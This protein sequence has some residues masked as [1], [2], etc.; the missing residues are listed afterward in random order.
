MKLTPLAEV[1]LYHPHLYYGYGEERG[2]SYQA[3]GASQESSS[4]G[5]INLVNDR[6][7]GVVTL[8]P[9]FLPQQNGTALWTL[10]GTSS[11]TA[12][13]WQ[14]GVHHETKGVVV[15]QP[16]GASGVTWSAVTA[17]TTVEPRW[18]L[19]YWLSNPGTFV[20]TTA[21]NAPGM[22]VTY[23]S[24][25]TTRYQFRVGGA[26]HP[27]M[28]VST[29]SGSAFHLVD[30]LRSSHTNARGFAAWA[31]LMLQQ[32]GD[33]VVCGIGEDKMRHYNPSFGTVVTGG[34]TVEGTACGAGLAW[35]P[36]HFQASGTGFGTTV[37]RGYIT[38]QT[39]TVKMAG[40]VGTGNTMSGT[41]TEFGDTAFEYEF[42]LTAGTAANGYGTSTPVMRSI[43]VTYPAV[44]RAPTVSPMES[45]PRLKSL[46]ENIRFDPTSL[47]IYTEVTANFDNHEKRFSLNSGIRACEV[48][49]GYAELGMTR[50]LSGLAG[51]LSEWTTAPGSERYVLHMYDRSV[52]LKSP[53]G[54]IVANLP[55]MDGWCIYKAMRYLANYGGIGD[56]SLGFPICNGDI[57][58]PCGHY[59]LP[60]GD[61]FH[62]LVR[63]PGGQYVWDCMQRLQKYCGHCLF[64]DNAGILRFYEWVPSTPGLY[65][66][67][68]TVAPE[69]AALNEMFAVSR[70][71]DMSGVRNDVMIVGMDPETWQPIVAHDRDEQSI[72]NINAANYMGYPARMV[73]ADSMFCTPEYA[74]QALDA[75]F[76]VARLP[77]NAVHLQ[78]WMQKDLFPL[79]VIGVAEAF[80][81]P[82]L[83]P[84]W[85]TSIT[86]E[87]VLREGGT[88][89]PI[90]PTCSISAN[91][92]TPWG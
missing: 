70:T 81:V 85:I 16:V 33:H 46:T 23:P 76:N 80:S 13:A 75:I 52:M 17:A 24:T 63:F 27:Q 77:A 14:A 28:L 49:I 58:N 20:G 56:S 60:W 1:R 91:W 57:D 73:W 2:F 3:S 50:R 36:M 51:H 48:D 10:G 69:P 86:N 38:T 4:W 72:T 5:L 12:V 64:F 40:R 83:H 55:Y 78:G 18:Y 44:R 9:V 45:L 15:Y 22:T 59:L 87:I 54:V 43:S 7:L 37:D 34:I 84:F 67:N 25:G 62:P 41:V 8:S 29:N 90:E 61:E 79:D 47:N 88:E 31:R 42:H 71:Q 19:D 66:K 21:T 32:I 11:G 6:E 65:K 74:G 89:Q 30:E 39:P 35:H 26:S 82:G 68:F 92:L 53:A